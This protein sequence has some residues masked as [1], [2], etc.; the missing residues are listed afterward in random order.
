VWKT[1]Y[2]A[3]RKKRVREQKGE[4]NIWAEGGELG[5]KK[6]AKP[7]FVTCAFKQTQFIYLKVFHEVVI[8]T[9]GYMKPTHW[10]KIAGA[11]K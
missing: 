11:R 10:H 4:E 5:T 9:Q 1:L 7:S 3:L 8:D 6:T 2:F